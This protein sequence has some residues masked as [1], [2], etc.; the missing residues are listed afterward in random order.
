MASYTKTQINNPSIA[1]TFVAFTITTF[2]WI[3]LSNETLTKK[4]KV[5]RTKNKNDENVS[6]D[7]NNI[8]TI[9]QQPNHLPPHIQRQMRKESKRI[10]KMKDLAM[11]TPMYDNVHMLVCLLLIMDEHIFP[12]SLSIFHFPFHYQ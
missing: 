11:K 10:A 3:C 8:R 9:S 6:R 12:F 5:K 7:D 2:V 1:V 4:E